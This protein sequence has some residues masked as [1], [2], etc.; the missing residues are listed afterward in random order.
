MYIHCQALGKS[1][2]FALNSDKN[3]KLSEEQPSPASDSFIIYS[4]PSSIGS[5]GYLSSSGTVLELFEV[6]MSHYTFY[7]FILF[8]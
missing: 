2:G 1:Q 8:Y 3:S 4:N 5:N 7:L 6:E